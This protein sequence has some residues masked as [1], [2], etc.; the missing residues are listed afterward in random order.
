MG[1]IELLRRT[2]DHLAQ[3]QP[4]RSRREWGEAL[5]VTAILLL[6]LLSPLLAD[7]VLG[8]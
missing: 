6:V 5:A 4:R 8:R 1:V 7:L 3:I 2:T